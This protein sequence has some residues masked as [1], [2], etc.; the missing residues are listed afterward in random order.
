MFYLTVPRGKEGERLSWFQ[1]ISL[2]T[3]SVIEEIKFH[4]KTR[5]ISQEFDLNG[6][7]VTSTAL[8]WPPFYSIDNCDQKNLR[9][10]TGYGYLAEYMDLLARRYNFTYVSHKDSNDDW[11]TVPKDGPYNL[12]GTWS[13]VMGDVINKKYDMSIS[14]WWWSSD[15]STMLEFVPVTKDP[16]TLVLTPQQSTDTSLF[17]RCFTNSS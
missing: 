4:P 11:G 9:C 8:S 10:E 5:L 14:S 17:I 6:L 16:I 7:S 2:S 12:S 3:G 13:G 1:G 15:R